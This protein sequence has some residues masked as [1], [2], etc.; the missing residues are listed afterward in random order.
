MISFG[1][2]IIGDLRLVACRMD[3]FACY[4]NDCFNQSLFPKYEFLITELWAW[5]MSVFTLL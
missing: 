3:G 4:L 2:E 1:I 5:K